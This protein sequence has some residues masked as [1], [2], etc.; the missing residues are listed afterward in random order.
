MSVLRTAI[1]N[2]GI[3]RLLL[4]WLAAW[5]S[6]WALTILI[7]LYAY[8]EGGAGLAGIAVIVRLLPSG[9]VASHVALLAD[10]HPRRTLLVAGTAAR[11]ALIALMAVAAAAD[12][13]AVVL[14]LSA[15]LTVATTAH[16]PAMGAL[17]PQVARTPTELAAANVAWG[18]MDYAAF[19]GGSLLSGVLAATVSVEAGFAVLVVPYLFAVA[20]LLGLPRDARPEP[21][22]EQESGTLEG[23]RTVWAHREIRLLTWLFSANV[24]VQGMVDLLIVVAAIELLDLGQA[25]AGWLNAA[26]GVGGIAG[27]FVA[28]SLLGRGRLA[29]GLAI[30]M[31]AAGVPFVIV[32]VWHDPVAALALLTVLGVGFALIETTLLTLTQRLAADDVLARVFGVQETVFVVGT[33]LG[34]GFAALL[35][36]LVGLSTTIVA[37]G[38][39]LPIIALALWAPLGRLEAAIAIPERPYVLLRGLAMFA[40]LPVSTIENLALRSRHV[41]H[42]PGTELMR[43]GDAGDR[44]YVID[45]GSVEIEIDGQVAAARH[46]GECVGEIALLRGIPR[47]ATVRATTEI[48]LVVLERDA[49]L[50]SVGSHALSQRAADELVENRR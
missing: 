5:L 9:F 7:A 10:R 18:G 2:P 6:E 14:V 28:V 24:F 32:G 27:G 4:A 19:L 17:L 34:S 49:F 36:E 30:G 29:S 37:T 3:R 44:F 33:A 15:L 47:T 48:G 31:I 1:R 16:K 20:I 43:Q 35:I 11:A 13:F 25:G 41:T 50:D 45:S 12:L 26:W 8:A 23:F 40:P 42:P 38:L 39:S 21:F 46:A 22:E